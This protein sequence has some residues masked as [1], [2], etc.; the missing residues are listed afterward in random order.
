MSDSTNQVYVV[1]AGGIGC[2]VSWALTVAGYRVCVVESNSTRRDWIGH[3]GIQ[4]KGWG[5]V[6][7]R[8]VEPTT[9]QKLDA[10]RVVVCV[11]SFDNP[12]VIPMVKHCRS[13][14]MIQN[15]IDPRLDGIVHRT[16]GIA[17]FIGEAEKGTGRVR[18]SRSGNVYLGSPF[19]GCD[20]QLSDMWQR[21]LF[22]AFRRLGICVKNVGD[23]LPYRN[24]KFVYNCAI[25]PLASASGVDNGKLLSD[26]LLRNLFLALL[27]ENISIMRACDHALA[28]VGPFS[29][30]H[31]A[32]ILSTPWLARILGYW[33]ER[34]L[35]G[36]YC[37]MAE[38]FASGRTELPQYLGYLLEMAGAL[39]C[40][41]N[42][43]LH[44][45]VMAMLERGSGPDIG[46][47]DLLTHK[48]NHKGAQLT[49]RLGN[50][51]P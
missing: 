3:H 21:L 26:V 46:I 34:S 45:E 15:G 13:V 16:D 9:F 1:G 6:R 20:K 41:V 5:T 35:R 8:V 50:Y 27:S 10:N 22:P 43:L 2:I 48:L 23:I 32:V 37:S 11:K 30:D 38:D 7:P 28:R 12:S 40:P 24:M 42:R 33:F 25:S 44:H 4:L 31:V 19:K 17:S 18:L 14:L 51:K 39:P 29:P 49:S 47:V 36:T